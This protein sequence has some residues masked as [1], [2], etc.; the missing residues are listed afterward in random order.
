MVVGNG[1]LS[2]RVITHAWIINYKEN[3]RRNARASPVELEARG[4][5]LN[6]VGI[7]NHIPLF[8]FFFLNAKNIN[9][10]KEIPQDQFK[11]RDS[12]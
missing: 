5:K 1:I 11:L 10:N 9:L 2:F 3:K 7:G 12:L 4:S 6:T 8:F